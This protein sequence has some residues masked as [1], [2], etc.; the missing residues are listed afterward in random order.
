MKCPLT[1]ALSQGERETTCAPSPWGGATIREG[2]G[3]G[4]SPSG[5]V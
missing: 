5:K 2:W 3:E 1:P 4:Q